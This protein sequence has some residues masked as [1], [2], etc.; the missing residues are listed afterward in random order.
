MQYQLLSLAFW[1][2]D[3]SANT[4]IFRQLFPYFLPIAAQHLRIIAYLRLNVS[5]K[6]HFFAHFE[7]HNS[8]PSTFNLGALALIPFPSKEASLRSALNAKAHLPQW[9]RTPLRSQSQKNGLINLYSPISFGV[10]YCIIQ[11]C[12]FTRA[13]T[14][15]KQRATP[16]LA[17]VASP[18]WRQ[19]LSFLAVP[20]A[21]FASARSIRRFSGS[22]YNQ[23]I[24]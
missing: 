14:R 18:F 5:R 21:T 19:R 7:P 9:G 11:S 10:Q 16:G 20:T 17:T 22:R 2:G 12:T 6:L 13:N 15:E 8:H 3:D 23:Q 1:T 24:H 4:P